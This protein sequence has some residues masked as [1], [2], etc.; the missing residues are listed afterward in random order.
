MFIEDLNNPELIELD[1]MLFDQDKVIA[2]LKMDL[3]LWKT[4]CDNLDKENKDVKST[5]T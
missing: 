4:A 5:S 1:R 3:H 2:G